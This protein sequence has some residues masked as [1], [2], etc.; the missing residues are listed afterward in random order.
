MFYYIICS[1]SLL[2]FIVSLGHT[3]VKEYSNI[4][5]KYTRLIFCLGLTLIFKYNFGFLFCGLEYEDSYAFSFLAREFA[6]NIYTTSFLSEGIGI[7]SINN[8]ELMQTYGGHF[9]TYSTLLSYPIKVFGY[10]LTLI[11]IITTIIN[12]I[13]LLI[14]SIFPNAKGKH[15]WMVAPSLFC[16]APIINLFGNTFLCE[17][18]SGMVVLSFCYLY[19][20][21]INNKAHPFIPLVAFCIAI[22]TKRENLAL[23][24]LPLIYNALS[25]IMSKQKI[26]KILKETTLYLFSIVLYFICFQNVFNIESVESLDI[27][28]STFSFLYF[29][30]L[31]PGFIE[32]LMTPFYFNIIFYLFLLSVVYYFF[33]YKSLNYGLAIIVLWS[34]FFL[35]YTFH[36]RGYFFV[37]EGQFNVFDTFRYLNNFYCLIPIAISF[38]VVKFKKI[39]V[40]GITSILLVLSIYPTYALRCEYHDIEQYNRFQIPNLVL[41]SLKEYGDISRATIITS[42]I[43]VYQNIIDKNIRMCDILN[44]EYLDLNDLN[45]NYYMICRDDEIQYINQRYGLELDL[46]KWSVI[47]EIFEY[48]IY[49]IEK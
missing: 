33:N 13:S 24:A 48:K 41:E 12:F 23:L 44:L 46:R 21:Y 36:Y 22:M 30:R 35:L 17:P 47:K 6:N 49:T 5:N 20:C 37:S 4:D 40:I 3:L 42:D 26:K 8:P 11:N 38:I 39:Y 9:I 10:S 2:I 25:I 27:N 7:G 45:T 14:L 34:L 31:A 1:I 29:C 19:F 28:G 43:L 18:F 32:A 16:V 15:M